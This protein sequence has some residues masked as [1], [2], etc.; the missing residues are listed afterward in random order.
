M[1]SPRHTKPAVIL[2]PGAFSPT[3]V[4]HQVIPLLEAAGH[5][6]VVVTLPS[7]GGNPPVQ[8]FNE[9]VSAV[10]AALKRVIEHE[11]GSDCLL[12]MHSY[13][14]VPGSEAV[15][16]WDRAERAKAG[17]KGG[18]LGLLYLASFVVPSGKSLFDM[19]GGKPPYFWDVQGDVVNAMK[20]EEV[21]FND[22][23]VD[24][25]QYWAKLMKPQSLGSINSPRAS[26][27]WKG[28]PSTYL[29]CE[30]DNA[31]PPEAQEGMVAAVNAD[32]DDFILLR[33]DA[34]HMPQ[35]SKPELVVQLIKD[36]AEGKRGKEVKGVAEGS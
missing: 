24:V 22:L 16:G 33:C 29:L 7:A 32:G 25:A 23:P 36:A 9:D 17:L 6:C 20:P 26:R 30:K 5:S 27:G 11:G 12:V 4:Y 31:I 13:G 10:T 34:G 1:F 3:S 18:V 35:L 2:V 28:I 21:F 8:D 15:A 19:A 14:G